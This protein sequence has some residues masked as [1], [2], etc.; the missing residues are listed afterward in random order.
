M[1]DARNHPACSILDREIAIKNLI[2]IRHAKS[3]WDH[4]GLADHERPLNRRGE[5][6]APRMGSLLKSRGLLPDR[7]VCSPATRAYLTARLLAKAVGYEVTDIDIHRAIYEQGLAGL[8]TVIHGLDASWRR[9][10]LVGHNPDLTRLVGELTGAEPEHLPTCA[11]ASLVFAVDDW[12]HVMAGA[13]RLAFLDY[14][15]RQAG[16]S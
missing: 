2:V 6:D 10:F 12:T 8:M 5:R 1:T 9:V 11:V 14:P 16:N 7:I 15:K 13:G 4:P 3:S